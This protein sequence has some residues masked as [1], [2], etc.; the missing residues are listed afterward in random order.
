MVW[1]GILW[2]NT[3]FKDTLVFIKKSGKQKAYLKKTVRKQLS[4]TESFQVWNLL[5]KTRFCIGQKDFLLD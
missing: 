2:S 4:L 3:Y 5:W 1:G